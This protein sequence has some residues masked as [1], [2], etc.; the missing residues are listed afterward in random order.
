[1]SSEV[2]DVAG[3]QGE[4][5]N[6]RHMNAIKTETTKKDYWHQNEGLT[7]KD[8]MIIGFMKR[9]LEIL[10]KEQRKEFLAKAIKKV[11]TNPNEDN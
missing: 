2:K 4:K 10:K 5:R 9:Y 6:I 1:M 7:L 11:W 8:R 3:W